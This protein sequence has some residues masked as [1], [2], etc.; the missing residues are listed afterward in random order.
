MNDFDRKVEQFFKNYQD[1]GMKKWAGFFL[2][3]HTLKINKDKAKRAMVYQKKPSMNEDEISQLLFKAFSD[4]YYVQVQLKELDDDGKLKADI[5]GFVEGYQ[6]QLII[7]S[8]Q[9]VA[10]D[11][12]N[13]V[14]IKC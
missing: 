8:G 3:D 11:D 9:K 6:E 4:H 10:I 12:I 13:N 2:S 1:R 7:I 5:C 14:T